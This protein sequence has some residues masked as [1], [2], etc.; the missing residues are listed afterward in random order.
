MTE[1]AI[2]PQET[3][4]LTA[5]PRPG[6]FP[7]G[8]P[9]SRVAVRMRLA[10]IRTAQPRLTFEMYVGRPNRDPM[11]YHFTDWAG[12]K[13]NGLMRIVFVPHAWL[14]PGDPVPVCPDCAKPF[15][16]DHE[17]L[18]KIFFVGDC[19]GVHVPERGS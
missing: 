14:A 18:G 8:S 12:D 7:I 11:R 6:D 16:K 15:R 2:K 5:T 13:K 3:L 9:R 19:V 10:K 17:S 4:P 1:M